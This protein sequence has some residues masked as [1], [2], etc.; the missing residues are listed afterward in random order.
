MT[1][2]VADLKLMLQSCKDSDRV[3]F[4]SNGDVV[5]PGKWDF[6]SFTYEPN[7][8][9]VSLGLNETQEPA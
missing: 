6:E 9:R 2:T 1:M 7:K 8:G 5:H 3:V 4:D